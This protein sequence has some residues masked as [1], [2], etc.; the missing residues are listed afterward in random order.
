MPNLCRCSISGKCCIILS[1]GISTT[2]RSCRDRNAVRNS[3]HALRLNAKFLL[4]LASDPQGVAG[5]LEGHDSRML[6]RHCETALS[7][8]GWAIIFIV[9]LLRFYE[10]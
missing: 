7:I 9:V 8:A 1:H 4:L 6:D 2:M 3:G 5:P 10:N